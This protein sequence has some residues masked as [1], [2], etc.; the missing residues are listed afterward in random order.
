MMAE[1]LKKLAD[2]EAF[3]DT[4]VTILKDLEAT[5]AVIRR[6]L[7]EL[8]KDVK[9]DDWVILSLAGHGYGEVTE[10]KTV[11]PGTWYFAGYTPRSQY[12][13]PEKELAVTGAEIFETLKAANCRKLIFL[14]ACHS[15]AAAADAGRDLRPDG[16]GPVVLSAAAANELAYEQPREDAVD[17]EVHGFFTLGMT[18]GLGKERTAADLNRDGI[19]TVGELHSF[20]RTKVNGL[21]QKY[22]TNAQTVI[23]SP[24]PL[25]GL[26]VAAAKPGALRSTAG[27]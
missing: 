27:N 16:K 24:N 13:S 20:A 9:P 8:V 2:K 26:P 1:V 6:A 12:N 22:E 17:G 10:D 19:L 15:G 21:T 5:P 14:D 25:F 4:K 7:E 23:V 3:A 11:I 18:A